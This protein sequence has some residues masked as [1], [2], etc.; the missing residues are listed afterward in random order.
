MRFFIVSSND[1]PPPP[2][3]D[4]SEVNIKKKP[5]FK[6]ESSAAASTSTSTDQNHDDDNEEE[7]GQKSLE[8][9]SNTALEQIPR[10]SPTKL[11]SKF[12]RPTSS[13]QQPQPIEMIQSRMEYFI[14]ASTANHQQSKKELVDDD[15]D[16]DDDKVTVTVTTTD[17]TSATPPPSMKSDPNQQIHLVN[18]L[19]EMRLMNR[20]MNEMKKK[21]N[22][23]IAIQN[24]RGG[25]GAGG[26]GAGVPAIKVRILERLNSPTESPMKPRKSFF[27]WLNEDVGF[28]RHHLEK[29]FEHDFLKGIWYC[30]IDF[31]VFDISTSICAFQQRKGIIFI[32]S[33]KN[34]DEPFKWI[35][36]TPEHMI[37]LVHIMKFK[38]TELFQVYDRETID[39]CRQDEEFA[40]EK[41]ANRLKAFGI[42]AGPM[43]KICHYL[44]QQIYNYISQDFEDLLSEQM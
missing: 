28:T 30:L 25:A 7:D 17:D 13:V 40:K 16:D 41:N 24:F 2:P 10:K 20:E 9:S 18:I 21:L 31:F 29:I 37:S 43:E 33:R 12:I 32:W 3:S 34:R 5:K 8:E 15:D 35:T 14:P 22:T 1:S 4:T 39:R 42:T 6:K 36:M 11:T 26:G 23:V 38:I 44:K 19:K 27:E